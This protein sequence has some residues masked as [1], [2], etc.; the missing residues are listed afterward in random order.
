MQ[1]L[2]IESANRYYANREL[3]ACGIRKTAQ[4]VLNP[5][6]D[7][8]EVPGIRNARRRIYNPRLSRILLFKATNDVLPH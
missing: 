8:N 1:P 4:D 3:F 5:T 7:W 2:V 6:N